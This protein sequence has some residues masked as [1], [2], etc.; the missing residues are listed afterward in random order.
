MQAKLVTVR[1]STP[2]LEAVHL[3]VTAHISGLPVVDATGAVVGMFT[4]TDALLAFD[5]AFD[6][7]RDEGEAE[8][9]HATV[10]TLE[11]GELA[12][13]DV[14]FVSPDASAA[15]VAHAMRVEGIHRVVV[16]SRERPEGILT[17]FDLLG[18]I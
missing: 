9:P 4:A 7:D 1:E 14:V 10:S 12:T 5:Q 15:D 3:L 2:L 8:D 16:G 18:A 13:P 11:V 6:D 17:A